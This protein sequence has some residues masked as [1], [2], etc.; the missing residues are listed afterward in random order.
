M[1]MKGI[2]F[3]ALVAITIIVASA[4]ANRKGKSRTADTQSTFKK[5]EPNQDNAAPQSPFTPPHVLIAK[6]VSTKTPETS[7]SP[8][9]AKVA[10]VK[11]SQVVE[12]K[13]VP[14]LGSPYSPPPSPKWHTRVA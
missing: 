5:P 12:E 4:Q 13:P 3:L 8:P 7:S 9:A 6:E 11:D 1:L 2:L 14:N 10:D